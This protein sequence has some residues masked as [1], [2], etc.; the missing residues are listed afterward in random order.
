MPRATVAANFHAPGAAAVLMSAADYRDSL[1]RLKP[2][3]FVN[4]RR[5]ESVSDEPLLAPG[6]A[7]TGV[8]YDFGQTGIVTRHHRRA[9]GQGCRFTQPGAHGAPLCR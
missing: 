8:A 2:R 5:I 3:V 1:R 7:A 9:A 4:G 6:I